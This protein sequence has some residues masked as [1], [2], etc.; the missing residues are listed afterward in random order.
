MTYDFIV[1]AQSPTPPGQNKLQCFT[2]EG[3]LA[4]CTLL[5]KGAKGTAVLDT[6]AGGY[7]GVYVLNSNINLYA[8]QQ[9]PLSAI[10]MLSFSY[11]GTPTNGSPRISLPIDTGGDDVTNEIASISAFWCNNGAGLVDAIKDPTCTIFLNSDGT[12]PVATNWAELV[13]LHPDWTVPFDNFVYVIADDPGLWTVS[14][15]TLGK[16]GK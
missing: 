10:S 9:T 16:P 6:T 5:T 12:T 8:G 1:G 11:T 7:A 2:D 3:G 4:S 15:V 14:N 13:A